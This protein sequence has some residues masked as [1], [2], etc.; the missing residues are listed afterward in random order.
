M[1]PKKPRPDDDDK[2]GPGRP[3]LMENPFM[4]RVL[5]PREVKDRLDA[6]AAERGEGLSAMIR[7]VLTKFADRH[8]ARK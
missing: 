4:L 1:P 7:D 2:P 3:P 8:E 5:V 6:I